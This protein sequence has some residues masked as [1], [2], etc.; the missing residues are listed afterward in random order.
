[1]LRGLK[2]YTSNITAIVTVAD[3][4]GGSGML[5][6]S[7]GMLPP[8]DIRNCLVA[9]AN[10][11]PLMEELMQYRFTEGDLKGQNF[12]NLFIAAMNGISVNFED[13]I[14]KMSDVL[15]VKGKVFPV[16]LENVMLHAILSDGSI[17][18]GESSIPK[19][20]IEKNLTIDKIFLEPREP[21]ALED[22]LFAIKDADCII[23]GPGSLYT[24][25]LPN[26]IID[27]VAKQLKDSSAMKVY[28]SNIMTQPGETTGYK[29]S[30]HIEAIEKVC[31]KG[32]I[33]IAVA[34]DGILPDSYFEKYK[35]D[36]QE[37]VEIDS[38]NISRNILIVKS[39]LADFSKGYVRHSTDKLSKVIM[40]LILKHTLPKS[41][42]R[43]LDYY[44]LAERLKEKRREE[45]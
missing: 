42:K 14:K 25:I 29:L 3:D 39:D 12:G 45:K 23:I 37:K 43:L 36:G 18:K 32:I 11:E 1:M 15:A 38:D 19:E 27:D 41:R 10:T 8:G 35:D 6:Q 33:N 24:S 20:C 13:A 7:L 31:G 30:D 28:V 5:R 17:V 21:K 16:T 2:Q 26:L 44:Y 40:D 34:N 22:A 9:L 4:G